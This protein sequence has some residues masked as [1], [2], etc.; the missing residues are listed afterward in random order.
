MSCE[1]ASGDAVSSATWIGSAKA[2]CTRFGLGKPPANSSS[3][4]SMAAGTI[5]TC[6]SSASRPAP[7]LGS[8]S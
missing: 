2:T 8:P 1:A 4:P 3:L 6:S 7:R 5:G